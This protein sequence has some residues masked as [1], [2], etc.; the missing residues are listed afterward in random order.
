MISS[1]PQ[2]VRWLSPQPWRDANPVDPRVRGLP[3]SRQCHAMRA[4]P[5]IFGTI[6][7]TRPV[8][9]QTAAYFYSPFLPG[10]N[11][12]DR[13]SRNSAKLRLRGAERTEMVERLGLGAR[14]CD[15]GSVQ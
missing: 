7:P 5:A 6:C 12:S 14:D 3:L 10:C 13:T 1:V 9:G 11:D 2:L 15:S 8:F 4:S